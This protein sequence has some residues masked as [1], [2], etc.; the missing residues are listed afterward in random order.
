MTGAY[1]EQI[2]VPASAV[3][4][5]PDGLTEREAAAFQV[6][7]RT[8]YH[9]LRTI[10]ELRPGRWVVVLGAAGADCSVAAERRWSD[11]GAPGLS[12]R[13]RASG[14]RVRIACPDTAMELIGSL[15]VAW[16]ERG[17]LGDGAGVHA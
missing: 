5:I 12:S 10:G 16:A 14:R 17:L 7:F 15:H 8:A 2:A 1:A 4:P 3:L 11:R 9:A 6:T 13:R